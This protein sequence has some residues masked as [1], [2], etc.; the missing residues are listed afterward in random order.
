MQARPTPSSPARRVAAPAGAPRRVGAP[1]PP[2]AAGAAGGPPR[3]DYAAFI[4]WGAPP[5]DGKRA[6]NT[7]YTGTGQNG[8]PN[9]VGSFILRVYIPDRGLDETGWF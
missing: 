9:F 5:A 6:P 3:R 7:M 1:P 8:E 4:A 2:S